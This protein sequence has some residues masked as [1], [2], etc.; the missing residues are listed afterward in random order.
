[1]ESE[2]NQAA[3]VLSSM[4]QVPPSIFTAAPPLDTPDSM[5]DEDDPSDMSSRSGNES[6][7]G[8][9][10]GD[11]M[12]SDNHDIAAGA[13]VAPR[14]SSYGALPDGRSDRSKVLA[15]RKVWTCPVP[16]CGRRY[17]YESSPLSPFAF[18]IVALLFLVA[19][20]CFHCFRKNFLA[21]TSF[22]HHGSL[23]FRFR[24]SPFRV[25]VAVAPEGTPFTILFHLLR[26]PY[27]S[28]PDQAKRRSISAPPLSFTMHIYINI[29]IEFLLEETRRRAV[30]VR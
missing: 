19:A 17:W 4:P 28:L 10:D 30:T 9:G 11:E 24:L 13:D 23:S 6:E 20:L 22:L 7:S 12:D 21:R 2:E 25:G 29:Y 5:D 27:T 18:A 15:Q 26:K 14:A 3:S 8:D 16:E 1:M